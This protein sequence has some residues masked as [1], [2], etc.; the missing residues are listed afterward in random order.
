MFKLLTFFN[1][2]QKEN[3]DTDRISIIVADSQYLIRFAL[4]QIV[5]A[6]SHLHLIAEVESE[7]ALL[8]LLEAQGCPDIIMMDYSEEGF[9]LDSVRKV[10]AA[11]PDT[12]L[13]IIS[14]DENKKNILKSLEWGV[15]GF[16]TKSC[17][18]EEIRDAIKASAHKDK[19][20]CTKVLDYLL[21]KSFSTETLPL[22]PTPLT[23]REIE[24][25]KL[26]SKGLIAKEIATLLNLSPHT[27]YTHRKK[28]MKKL[29]LKSASELVRYAVQHGLAPLE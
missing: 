4:K 16:L 22:S 12:G 14:A 10:R 18:E 3:M 26:I 23:N 7:E 6:E 5:R 9:Q 29:E 11:C 8:S 19:F 21:E 28:I 15:N 13:I 20:F 2:V 1:L 27:V 17:N 24:V 25:V